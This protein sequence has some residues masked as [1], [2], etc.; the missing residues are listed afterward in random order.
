[1][2]WF[3]F[4]QQAKSFT[5]FEAASPTWAGN[6]IDSPFDR[7]FPAG[8]HGKESTCSAGD[9]GL[10]SGLGNPLEKEVVTQSS[11]LTWKTPWM[12]EPGR[13][14]SMGLQRVGHN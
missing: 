1:M 8:S 6:L 14:Q 3:E 4:R 12:E 5:S 2:G 7:G 13:L 11:T 10:I 9:L